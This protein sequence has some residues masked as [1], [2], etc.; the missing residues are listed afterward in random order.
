MKK[1]ISALG[2]FTLLATSCQNELDEMS[3]LQE[4]E[5]HPTTRSASSWDSCSDCILQSGNSVKLPWAS[6]TSTIIPDEIREDIKE[7]DG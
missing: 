3:Y 2:L 7:E 1:I 4:Q 5:N 6:S